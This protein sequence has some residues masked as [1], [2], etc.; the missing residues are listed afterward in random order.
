MTTPITWRQSATDAD[1]H[2]RANVAAAYA[3]DQIQVSR[4]VR[5]LAGLRYDYFDLQYHDNRSGLDL[6]RP[7][8]LLS[9]RGALV[10]KPIDPVSI[11]GSF[12]MSYLPSSGDQFSSLTSITQQVK[13]EQFTNYEIGAKWDV[14]DNLSFNAAAYRLDRT[15]T[16]STDP[17]DPTRIIQTGSQRTNGV[18]LGV[19]GNIT[20]RWQVAGGYGYQNAFITSATASAALGAVVGQVPHQTVSLWNRY[21]FVRRLGAGLG[22]IY[23]SDMFAAI[24]D[25]VTLPSYVRTDA[26]VFV[27]VT[28]RLR[29]QLNVENLLNTKYYVNADSNTNISPG[30]P[31]AI[32]VALVTKF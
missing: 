13:P 19:A 22:L 14:R 24:D 20:P 6:K 17:N 32:R 26:A 8:N 11:Y 30:S 28:E 9:P 3:Q 15:N 5:V 25:T 21:Q 2:L 16:R 1:N 23:R 12:T 4:T 7:D 18:E 27:P 29:V 31:R 10:Y